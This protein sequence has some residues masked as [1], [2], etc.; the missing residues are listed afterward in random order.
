MLVHKFLLSIV[1]DSLLLDKLL[2]F[3]SCKFKESNN[4]E[5]ILQFIVPLFLKELLLL[6]N[7]WEFEPIKEILLLECFS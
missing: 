1:F 2:R 7:F 6:V 4:L 3:K 5:L